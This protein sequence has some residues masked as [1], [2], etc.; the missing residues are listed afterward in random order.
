[1][2]G[3][4]AVVDT[5]PPVLLAKVASQFDPSGAPGTGFRYTP[6]AWHVGLVADD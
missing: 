5:L 4:T 3:H 6:A 1:M 2:V